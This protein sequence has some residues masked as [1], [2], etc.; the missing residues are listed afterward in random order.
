MK[1][2]ATKL[3]AH[4]C[5]LILM[6]DGISPATTWLHFGQTHMAHCEL[7][8]VGPS[9]AVK[10]WADCLIWAAYPL[11][12]HTSS[13]ATDWYRVWTRML[14]M[15]KACFSH[16]HSF[17]SKSDQLNV[18]EVEEQKPQY[19]LCSPTKYDQSSFKSFPA[20]VFANRMKHTLTNT[21]AL[22]WRWLWFLQL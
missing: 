8:T 16:A 10:C 14:F 15:I 11:Y 18:W 12:A 1:T 2:Y 6:P 19:P 4:I 21:S 22:W 13:T 5:V 17:N 20:V 9:I 3:L 7:P